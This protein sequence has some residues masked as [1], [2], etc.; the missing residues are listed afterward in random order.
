MKA[1]F[2]LWTIMVFGFAGLYMGLAA[3]QKQE[4]KI[5]FGG[6]EAG[7]SVYEAKTAG[8][9]D[10]GGSFESTT[11]A[12]IQGVKIRSR[13][14]GQFAENGLTE[15]ELVESAA[16]QEKRVTAKEGKLKF[17]SGATTKEAEYKPMKAVF[18]NFHPALAANII[19]E[20]DRAKGGVQNIRWFSID[21]GA[22]L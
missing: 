1:N 8:P 7:F 4:M 16:G 14:T 18:A 6:Q 15:F 19:K 3:T 12:D 21:A 10:S 17:V 2:G 11:V 13:L 5:I 9:G 20:F 22:A